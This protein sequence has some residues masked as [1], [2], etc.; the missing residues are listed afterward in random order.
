MF[1]DDWTAALERNVSDG[2]FVADQCHPRPSK[3]ILIKDKSSRKWIDE[4][5][6]DLP[7]CNIQENHVREFPDKTTLNLRSHSP[8][9][10]GT[11]PTTRLWGT[12]ETPQP[13][14]GAI[15]RALRRF[16]RG[17]SAGFVS[18]TGGCVGGWV[19]GG[20]TGASRG[21]QTAC[22]A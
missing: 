14:V 10:A 5:T 4:S 16:S 17:G 18:S 21:Q 3:D 2:V 15:S 8:F 13:S 11:P 1:A 7:A 12:L 22:V 9:L 6:N 20:V 19:G